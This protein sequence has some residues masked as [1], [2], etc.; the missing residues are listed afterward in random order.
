MVVGMK[1]IY[2]PRVSGKSFMSRQG[3]REQL[4]LTKQ[5]QW[6]KILNHIKIISCSIRDTLSCTKD[7]II[8]RLRRLSWWLLQNID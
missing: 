2:V 3:L 4:R 7:D 8:I 5:H 6:N 1:H